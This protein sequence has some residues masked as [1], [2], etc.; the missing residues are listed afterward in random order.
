MADEENTNMNP[1]WWVHH[2]SECVSYEPDGVSLA[3]LIEGGDVSSIG[4]ADAELL[5]GK[6]Y[7]NG[8]AYCLSD[9]QR[10]QAWD[11]L[12]K[13]GE[14]FEHILAYVQN[15]G[16]DIQYNYEAMCTERERLRP[17]IG[18]YWNIELDKFIKL[19]AESCSRENTY[20][21]VVNH[22]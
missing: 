18:D 1:G 11:I 13:G 6:G 9:V 16:L 10:R 7:I 5:I 14:I 12:C 20:D 15:A 3:T 8:T 2:E 21:L 19:C 17:L 22:G 4:G